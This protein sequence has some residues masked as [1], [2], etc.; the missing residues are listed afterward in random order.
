MT[1]YV[2][3]YPTIKFQNQNLIW[4]T[5]QPSSSSSSSTVLDSA[6][7]NNQEWVLIH[8]D[9][10]EDPR[11]RA[12]LLVRPHTKSIG[13]KGSGCTIE[14]NDTRKFLGLAASEYYNNPS[15]K[16]LLLGVTGTN[17]K[18][19]TALLIST[20]LIERGLKVA[21]LGTLGLKIYDKG[22][23]TPIF[24]TETGFTTPDAPTLQDLMAQLVSQHVQALVME[25]SS[26]A[27]T[28]GRIAGCDFDA[29]GFTNL[30][31]DHLDFHKS[32]QEYA[33]AKTQIFSK[34]LA[35]DYDE[36]FKKIFPISALSKKAKRA[37]VLIDDLHGQ[38]ICAQ[39][40]NNIL[41]YPIL[42]NQNF[43]IQQS[44]INGN[45]ILLSN[46]T[47]LSSPLIG[48]FNADNAV[49]AHEL[50]STLNLASSKAISSFRGAGGRMELVSR[51]NE[52]C[53]VVD[54]AHTPDALKKAIATLTKVSSQESKIIVIFGCG[55]NRD[56]S[57][58]PLMGSIASEFADEVILTSDNPRDENPLVI[59]S[60]I[61]SGVLHKHAHKMTTIESREL[62]I[63]EGIK[64]L[65]TRPQDILLIAGKG[66]E[67]YQIVGAQ[68]TPFSDAQTARTFLNLQISVSTQ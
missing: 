39:I 14:I 53:V 7:K 33:H 40:P 65:Y 46:N 19:T 38:N 27:S 10:Y 58:R 63:A 15:S 26:H 21:E 34:Y 4:D 66:H 54:Y 18:T 36:E 43:Q 16:L 9:A 44:D 37:V 8:H 68:Q 51:H 17:G 22:N 61:Q 3:K 23:P 12:D 24:E 31:Q 67:N 35:H 56:K 55:G 59:I 28:L 57:K 60:E 25:V 50:L 2:K 1:I 32:M 20:Q 11:H 5:R 52:P 42:K 13:P 64:R 30:T 29:I 6:Q 49:L 45:Q 48:E 47:T 41:L 62:A